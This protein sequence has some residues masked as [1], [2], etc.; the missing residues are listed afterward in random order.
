MLT[1]LP[2]S[3]VIIDF[4]SSEFNRMFYHKS[5][6]LSSPRTARNGKKPAMQAII[7]YCIIA[8]HAIITPFVVENNDVIGVPDIILPWAELQNP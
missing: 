8:Y 3:K 2:R 4:L 5:E 1:S 7:F 6:R